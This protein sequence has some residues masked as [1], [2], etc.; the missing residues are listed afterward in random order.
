MRNEHLELGL[1]WSSG[2]LGR[3]ADGILLVAQYM[4]VAVFLWLSIDGASQGRALFCLLALTAIAVLRRVVLWPAARQ[5]FA[6]AY[7]AGLG[8]RRDVLAHLVRV[9]FGAFRSMDG[10]KL[11]RALSEDVLWLEN[12]ASHTRPEVVANGLVLGGCL[13]GATVAWPVIGLSACLIMVAG[14]CLL[15]FSSRVLAT[16]LER[17][18]RSLSAVSLAMQEQAEGVSVLRAFY[19]GPDEGAAPYAQSVARMRDGAWRGIRQIAPLAVL[20]RM[21]MDLSAALAVLLAV[22]SYDGASRWDATRLAL[23]A[24]LVVCATVPARNLAS[25]S[26]MFELARIGR[27]NIAGIFAVPLQVGG[28][29]IRPDTLD[30][31]Y[32]NVAFTHPGR[33]MPAL[34]DI[35]F[36]AG[37][38]EMVAFVGANGSGKTTCMQLLMRFW[39]PDS[40]TISIGG[41]DIREMD[42]PVHAGLIA[43]VFQETL[44]FN[45]TIANNIRIG[46][47]SASDAEVEAAARSAAVHDAVMAFED[48]YRTRVGALG[49]RLSGGERQ[50]IC[51]ARAILK[52]APIVILDEATS[53]LDPEN[54]SAIQQAVSS[55]AAGRTL[56]VI[57]HDLPSIVQADRIVLLNDGCIEAIGTH[58]SLLLSSPIYARLWERS[59]QTSQWSIFHRRAVNE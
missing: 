37:Q 54:Q 48:G 49:T 52:N 57:A 26:A 17:R 4:L 38:G 9:P 13:A 22:L 14:V 20:F 1:R 16:G 7:A 18:A 34:S 45:E 53:A 41:R 8:L 59:L 58:D 56:F 43:P 36:E 47:P 6:E 40:G 25:F 46:R 39:E 33:S 50:R 3:A 35:S 28:E 51:I 10:G 21:V 27:R 19:A 24:L 31:R 5:L 12:H 42:A 11:I 44:L 23:A 29:A 2:L 15:N 32:E 55:L 30:I